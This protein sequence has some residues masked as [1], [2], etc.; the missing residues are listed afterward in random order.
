MNVS[1]K[2][3]K[4]FLL[5]AFLSPKKINLAHSSNDYKYSIYKFIWNYLSIKNLAS[6]VMRLYFLLIEL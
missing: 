3:V 2:I 6:T 1:I 5:A 4:H